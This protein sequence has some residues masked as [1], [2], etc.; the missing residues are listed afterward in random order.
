MFFKFGFFL[1]AIVLFPLV[2]MLLWNALLPDLFGFS[3]VNYWQALGLLILAKILFGFGFGGGRGKHRHWK[4][5]WKMRWENMSA[6][7][8]AHYKQKYAR[9]CDWDEKSAETPPESGSQAAQESEDAD[10]Q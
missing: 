7:E 3:E 9:W 4:T 5:K 1:L 8:R 6:E 10:Q 2:V